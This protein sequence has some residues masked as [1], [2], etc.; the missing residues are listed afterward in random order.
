MSDIQDARQ[1]SETQPLL[2]GHR[3]KTAFL[4]GT[5]HP[6]TRAHRNKIILVLC[7]TSCTVILTTVLVTTLPLTLNRGDQNGTNEQNVTSEGSDIIVP[8][9][10]L[11][12][13]LNE[14][15]RGNSEKFAALNK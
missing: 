8:K 13:D 5:D 4:P 1:D 2:Q 3:P 7:L 6:L 14:E 10:T 9:W 12:E 11:H 15:E